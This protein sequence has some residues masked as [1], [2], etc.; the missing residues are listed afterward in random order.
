MF[1]LVDGETDLV[2]IDKPFTSIELTTFADLANLTRL[3]INKTFLKSIE[4]YQFDYLVNLKELFLADNQIVS[5]H[6]NSFVKLFQL[7]L[8]CLNGNRLTSIDPYTFKGLSKLKF[9]NMHNNLFTQEK[10]FLYLENNISFISFKTYLFYN[11]IEDVV[12]FIQLI[13]LLSFFLFKLIK[14]V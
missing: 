6:P 2:L 5:V 8:L 12:C 7:E 14:Y 1:N 11:N 9:I 3:A 10:L 4:A 13:I